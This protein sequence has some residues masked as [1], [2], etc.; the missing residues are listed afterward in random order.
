MM[1]I[2]WSV[3]EITKALE[4]AGVADDT[5]VVFTSD[6]GPW[7]SYGNH[8]GMTPYREAK[9]TGFDG[10]TRSACV[11]RCP[12]EIPA[13]AV[14][15]QAFCSVDFL[16]TFAK[17]AGAEL[18][19]NPIDGVDVWDLITC[20]PEATNPHDYYPVST[21]RSF[22]GV[23]SGDGKWKLHLPHT[24]RTLVEAGNDG[25][26]GSYDTAS[27]ELSLFDMENDPYE[28]TN[29]IDE[30]PEVAKKLQEIAEAHRRQWWGGE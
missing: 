2:D 7:I 19:E 18:P 6:N 11:M 26:P 14:S 15:H 23:V 1:E 30:H 24:Y 13:G 29:V 5:V 9:G 21:G 3:G 10:G 17:L 4:E 25:Q 20:Q 22:D 12:G 8:A 28:T 27:I 16:P